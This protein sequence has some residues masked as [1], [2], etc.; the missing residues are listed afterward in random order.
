MYIL[1]YRPLLIYLSRRHEVYLT[2]TIFLLFELL[3]L[4]SFFW[5]GE[6]NLFSVSRFNHN[7]KGFL[8]VKASFWMEGGLFQYSSQ[9]TLLCGTFQRVMKSVIY[10]WVFLD[11]KALQMFCWSLTSFWHF[12]IFPWT[13]VYLICLVMSTS[14]KSR[15]WY[16]I[17]PSLIWMKGSL[18]FGKL[19]S[20]L[21]IICSC[22]PIP[23]SNPPSA[24]SLC[25][26]V[27]SRPFFLQLTSDALKTPS[28]VA[29][30]SCWAE[31]CVWSTRY[32][33]NPR[34]GCRLKLQMTKWGLLKIVSRM[35]AAVESKSWN[36]Y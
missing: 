7:W 15:T 12:I 33:G 16:A 35:K 26:S 19:S 34:F 14:S 17:Y 18:T 1:K 28:C 10:S 29:C 2:I 27:S 20:H 22:W 21:K 30:E 24:F 3:I 36:R 4:F 23:I 13:L 25:P 9:T 31:M 32:Q 8:F 5:W 6:R 11:V